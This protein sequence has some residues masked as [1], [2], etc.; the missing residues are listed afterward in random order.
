MSIYVTPVTSSLMIQLVLMVEILGVTT[1]PKDMVPWD[2]SEAISKGL[3]IQRQAV[4]PAKPH[5]GVNGHM[6]AN[7]PVLVRRVWMGWESLRERLE[8]L[9][10][11]SGGAELVLLLASRPWMVW[12][13]PQLPPLVRMD[14]E[15]FPTP[16][17]LGLSSPC[18][19][20]VHRVSLGHW[21]VGSL[22]SDPPPSQ[23]GPLPGTPPHWR[24]RGT[25]S[26][27][28]STPSHSQLVGMAP[29]QQMD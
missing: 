22:D 10:V 29:L 9:L 4:T 5:G 17:T 20:L 8:A 25:T 11:Q 23:K 24:R 7:M 15:L 19:I 27:P 13:S 16:R 18:W 28:P 14:T 26:P 21:W 3:G 12:R 6:T 1:T 2:V